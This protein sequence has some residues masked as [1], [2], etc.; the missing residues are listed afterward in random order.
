VVFRRGADG[1]E[2]ALGEQRDRLTG[3]TTVRLPK[4]K[5]DS[6]ESLE[7]TALREVAEETG[8]AGRIV[9]ELPSVAYVYHQRGRPVEK[10]VHFFLMELAEESVGETDGELHRVFWQT[11]SEAEA[12]L[13][14]A[15][16]QQ[17]VAAARAE[18]EA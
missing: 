6:G 1:I 15:T 4:G 3:E 12:A 7:E 14:F 10:T 9:G 13:T 16:E 8:L 18:L 11:L 2:V 5:P 17:V